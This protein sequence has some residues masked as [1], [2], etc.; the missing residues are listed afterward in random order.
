[1]IHCWRTPETR[2]PPPL[3]PTCRPHPPC[4]PRRPNHSICPLPPAAPVGEEK[5]KDAAPEGGV[6]GW[7]GRGGGGGGGRGYGGN[8]D[9]LWHVVMVM[10]VAVVVIVQMV[11][12]DEIMR[13]SDGGHDCT[14][15][16]CEVWLEGSRK[17]ESYKRKHY[18][19]SLRTIPVNET[20]QYIVIRL[21][22]KSQ[23]FYIISSSRVR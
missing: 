23:V 13:G 21:A 12:E 20:L 4:R 17:V 6:C 3:R 19:Q 15:G 8:G 2:R 9:E 5:V 11:T 14:D 16:G 7:S 1:M 22:S 10:V 18:D